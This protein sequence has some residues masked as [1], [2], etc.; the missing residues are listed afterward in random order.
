MVLLES[1]HRLRAVLRVPFFVLHVHHGHSGVADQDRFRESAARHARSECERRGVEFLDSRELPMPTIERPLGNE[2]E[3]RAYRQTAV[4]KALA[5]LPKGTLVLTGHHAAD[6]LETQMIRL[7]RGT[8]AQG[9]VSFGREGDRRVRPLIDLGPAS[10]QEYARE[11]RLAWVDDPSNERASTLR[12]WL[13]V[14]WLPMLETY[15]PG[16]LRRLAQSLTLVSAN[17]ALDPGTLFDDPTTLD[18]QRFRALDHHSQKT[19][20]AWWMRQS[21][22]SGYGS[23]HIR[24]VLRRLDGSPKRLTFRLLGRRWSMTETRLRLVSNDDIVEVKARG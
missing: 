2:S 1:H 17:V 9:L 13:R 19:V 12:N 21:G 23:A 10:L 20:L 8:G 15:R 11:R 14:E 18:L 6:A 7:I 4:Q 3:L 16:A 22:L 5:R 24:E